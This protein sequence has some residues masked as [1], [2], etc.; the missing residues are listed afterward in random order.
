[1]NLLLDLE[2]KAHNMAITL[3]SEILLELGKG[4]IDFS[5]DTFMII[6]MDGTFVYDPVTMQTYADISAEELASGSGY[7]E[8]DYDLTTSTPWTLDAGTASI[9]WVAA[10]WTATGS[11]LGPTKAAVILKRNTTLN[12]SLVIGC[13][14]F[15]SAYT[16]QAGTSITIR[17]LGFTLGE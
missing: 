14:E 8:A 5:S 10:E 12:D 6:L 11:D 7:T 9:T 15:T 2:A 4:T 17:N 3:N 16:I 13:E 1:M